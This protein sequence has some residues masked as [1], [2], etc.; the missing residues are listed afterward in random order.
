ME[1]ALAGRL[2][3]LSK[4]AV[5]GEPKFVPD[6]A[7]EYVP[8]F[9]PRLSPP[10]PPGSPCEEELAVVGFARCDNGVPVLDRDD[11]TFEPA[12][13]DCGCRAPA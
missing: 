9:P 12:G 8:L 2:D 11:V 5:V 4:P 3:I 13:T 7:G 1:P 10:P 6:N